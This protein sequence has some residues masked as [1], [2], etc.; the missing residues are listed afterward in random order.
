MNKYSFTPAHYMKQKLEKEQ[1]ANKVPSLLLEK[2][3]IE[4]VKR[5]IVK[6]CR[7]DI[8]SILKDFKL[9]KYY[10]LI[11]SILKQLNKDKGKELVKVIAEMECPICLEEV[12]EAIKLICNHLFCEGCI[13]KLKNDDEI[14]CPLCRNIQDVINDYELSESDMKIIVDEFVRSGDEYKVGQNYCMSFDNII[15]DI[16]K[17]KGIKLRQ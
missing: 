2:I 9:V 8:K 7:S 1:G 6:P 15:A 10:D 12:K 3:G 4:L 14:K 11:P 17:K 5:E 13:E 16:C